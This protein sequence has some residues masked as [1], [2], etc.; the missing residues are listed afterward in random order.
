MADRIVV[1]DDDLMSLKLAGRVFDK[2]G[3]EGSYLC[4]G[5]EALTFFN[6][7][8]IPDL[9]LLDVHM[10]DV[11]GFDVL[12]RLKNDP[13]Y[14]NVPVIFLT[15]DEDVKTETAGL[16]AGAA[17]LSENLLQRKCC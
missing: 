17:D 7:R 8:V 12:K 14:R 9:I 1:V 16:H 11:D 10:P 4:S 13:F 3:I 15:G 5:T 2:A 6:G